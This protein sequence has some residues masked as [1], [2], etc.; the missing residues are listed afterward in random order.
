MD[1]FAKI[2]KH[3][4]AFVYETGFLPFLNNEALKDLSFLEKA[5]ISNFASF[6]LFLVNPK[7]TEIEINNQDVSDKKMNDVM[8]QDYSYQ[9]FQND[10]MEYFLKNSTRVRVMREIISKLAANWNSFKKKQLDFQKLVASLK[11][12]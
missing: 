6:K 8:H 7:S 5:I 2:T 9:V 1:E 3:R 11:N 4:K 12:I 10:S